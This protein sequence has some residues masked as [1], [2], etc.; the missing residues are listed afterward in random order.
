M[1]CPMGGRHKVNRPTSRSTVALPL[2]CGA[3]SPA[4]CTLKGS[5]CICPRAPYGA[6][7]VCV[8]QPDAQTLP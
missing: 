8:S 6:L 2:V 5:D 3:L 4:A 1:L 7:P